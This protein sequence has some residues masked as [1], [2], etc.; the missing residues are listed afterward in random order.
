MRKD[1]AG[2][3]TISKVT[4]LGTTSGTQAR[5][6]IATGTANSYGIFAV[7]E[8]GSS[9]SSLELSSGD[10]VTNGM[11]FTAGSTT[12]NQPIVFRQGAS[13]RMRIS[14]SGS[15][16]IGINSPSAKLEVAGD[17][18]TS[19]VNS[20]I[21]MTNT[22]AGART[23]TLGPRS[24]GHFYLGDNTSGQIRMTVTSTGNVG[25]GASV[26]SNKFEVNGGTSSFA[27][28]GV[29][30][31][32]NSTNNNTNKIGFSNNGTAVG[33]I[34][35]NS[36]SV[37]YAQNASGS[38]TMG[39][40][41]SGNLTI[42]GSNYWT[43]DGRL[44]TDVQR[45]PQSLAKI[46]QINGVTYY[47]RP[48]LGKSPDLQMGV[49]AQN[50]EAVFPQAVKTDEKGFKSVNYVALISPIL[51]AVKELYHRWADDSQVLHREIN[52]L[53]VR[54]ARAEQ[55]NALMKAHLCAKDPQAAFCSK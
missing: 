1:Q 3:A 47:W 4:N 54:A 9:A 22:G 20:A 24:D 10:G 5:V 2:A 7:S 13:E 43:S 27:G 38:A 53:K 41:S 26:P 8:N 44:K 48:D 12:N 25:V 52:E 33:Y 29:P 17:A 23:F 30:V 6:D 31:I 21:W 35:A 15:V 18:G 42:S 28:A 40:D 19:W 39:L 16:G 36:S 37:F 49:I 32:V 55:E 46:D 45:I 51:E 14:S 34:G 11:F 50:V